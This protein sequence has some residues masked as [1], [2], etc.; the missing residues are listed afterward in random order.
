MEITSIR[1]V[2]YFDR[3]INFIRSN[4]KFETEDSIFVLTNKKKILTC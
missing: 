3:I 1:V 2:L 4:L